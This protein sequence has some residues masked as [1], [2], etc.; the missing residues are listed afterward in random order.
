MNYPPGGQIKSWR[1]FGLPCRAATEDLAGS[2]QLWPGG[3]MDSSVDAT[4]TKQT[5][6]GSIDNGINVQ[7]GDI[8]L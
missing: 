3:A 8:G 1:N 7:R 5:V 6:V 2:Q 4:S